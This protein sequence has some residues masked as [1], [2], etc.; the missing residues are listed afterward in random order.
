MMKWFLILLAVRCTLWLCRG[1]FI[2]I[3]Q[4][5]TLFPTQR[6][7]A[8]ADRASSQNRRPKPRFRTLFDP[9]S[10]ISRSSPAQRRQDQEKDLS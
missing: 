5:V 6:A 1:I 10:H 2:I 8:P 9:F 7:T 3:S 4:Y